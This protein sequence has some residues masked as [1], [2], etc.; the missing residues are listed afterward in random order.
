MGKVR[1]YEFN[2]QIYPRLLWIA[3]TTE[4]EIDDFDKMSEMDDSYK[5]VVDHAHNNKTDKG[6][7]MIRFSSVEEMTFENITH[8]AGHAAM[9]I[10]R[11]IEGKID[12]DNQEY[13][14]YLSGWIAK[15]CGEVREKEL[16]HGKETN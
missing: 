2:P 15:C 14:C 6:G 3:V 9:E 16:N 11:Y 5:A 8:E 12:L 7:I 1:V 10:I 13:F 4:H